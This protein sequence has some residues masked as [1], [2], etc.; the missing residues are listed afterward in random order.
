MSNNKQLLNTLINNKTYPVQNLKVEIQQSRVLSPSLDLQ[1]S[2]TRTRYFKSCHPVEVYLAHIIPLRWRTQHFNWPR[3][4]KLRLFKSS[5][6]YLHHKEKLRSAPN[7]IRSDPKDISFIEVTNLSDKE[8]RNR[9]RRRP[10][11]SFDNPE[12]QYRTGADHGNRYQQ[13]LNT[14]E[15]RY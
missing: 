13:T 5:Q 8:E 6:H 9:R 10:V 11:H 15:S 14:A 4:L 3:W 2:T 12:V 1:K 7:W